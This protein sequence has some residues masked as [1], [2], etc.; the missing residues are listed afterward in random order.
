MYSSYFSYHH[1][2]CYDKY[3]I[4]VFIYNNIFMFIMFNINLIVYILIILYMYYMYHALYNNLIL[5]SINLRFYK[6]LYY[7]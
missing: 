7:M 1:Y 2:V 6:F 4:N 5:H 3:T